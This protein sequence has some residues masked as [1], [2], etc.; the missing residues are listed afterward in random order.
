MAAEYV[1]LMRHVEGYKPHHS[2]KDDEARSKTYPTLLQTAERAAVAVA[3]VLR[4]ML[5]EQPPSQPINLG[6]IWHAPGPEPR[7]TAAIVRKQ[8]GLTQSQSKYFL[9]PSYIVSQSQGATWALT[10]IVEMIGRFLERPTANALLIVGNE[11]YTGWLAH[12]MTGR[13]IPIDRGEL[14]C[15]VRSQRE[16]RWRLAWTIH[17]ND[18]DNLA[19]IQEKIGYKMDAAKVMG[20]FITALITFVITQFL[21]H[22]TKSTTTWAL[23]ALTIAFLLIA[24]SLFFLSLFFYDTLRMPPRFWGSR[25]PRDPARMSPSGYVSRPPS[26][27]AWVLYQN[28]MRIWNRIFIPAVISVGV[29]LLTLCQS[30]TEPNRLVEW[31]IIPAGMTGILVIGVWARVNRPRLGTQD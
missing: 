28:M 8:A 12:H 24:A 2:G 29:A 15:L 13:E 6:E 10:H 3:G 17:P 1:L 5:C 11:P 4:N 21:S 20:A 14:I 27:S 25:V 23:R 7:E 26:S 19:S 16:K 18:K 30:L 22:P 31:W 9:S